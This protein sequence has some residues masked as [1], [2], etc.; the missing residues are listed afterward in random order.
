M[1]RVQRPFDAEL[2]GEMRA[3]SP[4]RL[5]IRSQDMFAIQSR[6]S[7]GAYASEMAWRLSNPSI[8]S[9]EL[10]RCNRN[11]ALT[12]VGASSNAVARESAFKLLDDSRVQSTLLDWEQPMWR[13]AYGSSPAWSKLMGTN[14]KRIKSRTSTIHS[15]GKL[16]G[17]VIT[18]WR[19]RGPRAW[20]YGVLARRAGL[21]YSILQTQEDCKIGLDRFATRAHRLLHM[22]RAAGVPTSSLGMEIAF[23]ENPGSTAPKNDVTPQRAAACTRV[24]YNEG[25]KGFFLWAHPRGLTGYFAALPPSIRS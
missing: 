13:Y 3:N 12:G 25:V 14:A 21:D 6:G 8:L 4:N 24:A 20:D 18:A 2:L 5:P 11:T 23:S 7:A 10:F 22:Y 16:A 19:N 17:A 15:N 9:G 1:Y